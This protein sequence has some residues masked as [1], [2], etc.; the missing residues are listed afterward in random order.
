MLLIDD[1]LFFPVRS[2]LWV[3]QEIHNAAKEELGNEAEA[4]RGQ[5]SH[6]YMMLETG[7][8]SEP[9]FDAQEKTLLDRLDVLEHRRAALPAR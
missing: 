2:I 1:I 7:A 6:L 9:E 3:F 8:M 4:V 5:L